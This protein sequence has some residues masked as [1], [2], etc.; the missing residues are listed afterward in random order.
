MPLYRKEFHNYCCY[1]FLWWLFNNTDFTPSS[2]RPCDKNEEYRL[3]LEH[4]FMPTIPSKLRSVTAIETFS[5]YY[6]LLRIASGNQYNAAIAYGNILN[7]VLK[8]LEKDRRA[9]SQSSDEV[10]DIGFFNPYMRLLKTHDFKLPNY[11]DWILNQDKKN[12][13]SGAKQNE[14][15]PEGENNSFQRL[16]FFVPAVLCRST[17]RFFCQKGQLVYH[18]FSIS[19][20]PVVDEFS[21]STNNE[22]ENQ[23][24]NIRM[25]MPLTTANGSY[26]V[27][28]L[29]SR[30][31]SSR[32]ETSRHIYFGYLPSGEYK[33]SYQQRAEVDCCRKICEISKNN[34]KFIVCVLPYALPNTDHLFSVEIPYEDFRGSVKSFMSDSAL[35][36]EHDFFLSRHD[37]LINDFFLSDTL[38]ELSNNACNDIGFTEQN[39]YLSV[40]DQ[41]RFVRCFFYC[42]FRPYLRAQLP[43]LVSENHTC[44]D[45]IDRGRC[46][47]AIEW[48]HHSLKSGEYPTLEVYFG[49][50]HA[51]AMQVKGRLMNEENRLIFCDMAECFLKSRQ[52][53]VTEEQ[54]STQLAHINFI[55]T[56]SDPK[57]FLQKI[58]EEKGCIEANRLSN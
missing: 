19:N 33:D 27:N 56:C 39:L 53:K 6:I 58:S 17:A 9:S 55:K 14:H 5:D 57:V 15:H 16:K 34:H 31:V 52:F 48:L 47:F 18:P 1:R 3:L 41:R 37:E 51:P 22:G 50:I 23:V 30:F 29:F 25:G 2:L 7:N 32:N 42:H 13:G 4:V 21:C 10:A 26:S 46:A 49:L 35:G 28:P 20:F 12:T 40:A 45:G 44:R 8:L 54:K 36:L 43:G 11:L 38:F 24:K